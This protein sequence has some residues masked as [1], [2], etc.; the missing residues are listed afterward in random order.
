MSMIESRTALVTGGAGFIG[1]YLTTELLAR[2]WRVVVFDDLSTGAAA[3][4]VEVRDHRALTVLTGSITDAAA[5]GEAAA[6]AEVIVHLAAAVGVQLILDRPVETIE[7]NVH[8]TENVLE[9]A[10]AQQARVIVASTSEVYGKGIRYPFS[11]DD[12]IVLGATSRSRWAYAASK[13]VDEFLCFAH[14]QENGLH[15][16]PVRFFNTV[17]ARQTGRYG[18]VVPRLVRQALRGEELTVYGDGTQRRCFCDVRDVVR[19]LVGLIDMPEAPVQTYNI[20]STEETTITGLAERVLDVTGSVSSIKYIPYAEAY[21]PGFDDMER[22]LP[23]TTRVN[24]LLGWTPR[25]TLDDIIESVAAHERL[26]IGEAG[27]S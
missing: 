21:S 26:L 19:A 14:H 22:R 16:I 20:G 1:S 24:K 9:A 2:G 11:E 7:T 5:V 23:D 27:V 12:D 13:M 6:G 25:Y 10:L 4:L 18:M 15:A 8:G 17:G 3:N